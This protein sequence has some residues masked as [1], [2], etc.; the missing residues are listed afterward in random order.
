[1]EWGW[2][3][4]KLLFSTLLGNGTFFPNAWNDLKPMGRPMVMANGGHR[5][6]LTLDL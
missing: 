5:T 4:N 1:M 3:R 6:Y 2:E